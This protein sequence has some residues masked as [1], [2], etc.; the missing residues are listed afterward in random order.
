LNRAPFNLAEVCQIFRPHG[1]GATWL[2]ALLR[3]DAETMLDP[4]ILQRFIDAQ[5]WG[6]RQGPA[7]PACLLQVRPYA[8]T[9]HKTALDH[10]SRFF[11]TYAED[12]VL[13]VDIGAQDVNGS[14]RSVM[15]CSCMVL[16]LFWTPDHTSS[17][18]LSSIK[19][20]LRIL[21]PLEKS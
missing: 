17:Q 20:V 4:Y 5:L 21:A 11:K 7:F 3:M 13:I 15:A 2:A 1:A 12:G 6:M 8:V 10:E 14:L 9:M 18:S 19:R 16:R